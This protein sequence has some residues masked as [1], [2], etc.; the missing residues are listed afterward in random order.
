VVFT[1]S[2]GNSEAE[3]DYVLTELPPA[4]ARLRS[5]SPVWRKKLAAVATG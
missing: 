4:V 5:F 3:V 1:L 2:S